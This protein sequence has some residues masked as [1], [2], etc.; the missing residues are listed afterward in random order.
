MIRRFHDSDGSIIRHD[1]GVW[2]QP[3]DALGFSPLENIDFFKETEEFE[4]DGSYCG[5]P[6]FYAKR[7]MIARQWYLRGEEPIE[8]MNNVLTTKV[9]QRIV[10]EDSWIRFNFK[11]K[12]NFRFL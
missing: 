3:V 1:S 4:C 7:E 2:I 5:L 6:Y 11:I 12:G 8:I 10:E 9:Y